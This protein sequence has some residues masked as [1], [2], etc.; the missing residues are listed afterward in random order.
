MK[1]REPSLDETE[2]TEKVLNLIKVLEPCNSVIDVRF[3]IDRE[4]GGYSVV[5]GFRVQHGRY[6]SGVPCLGGMMEDANEVKYYCFRE[7]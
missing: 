5:R 3:P 4:K 2:A 7:F 1:A 6:R